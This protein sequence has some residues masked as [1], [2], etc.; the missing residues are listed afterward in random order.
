[1]SD[2]VWTIYKITNTVN[3]KLYIGITKRY[4]S[5]RWWYHKYNARD[6]GAN[7]AIARA[8][9]K[10]GMGNFS[11]EVICTAISLREAVAIERG[12]IAAYG[13]FRPLGY[14]LTV[15][16]EGVERPGRPPSPETIAKMRAA[17]LG[18]KN[19]PEHIANSAA[20]HRGLKHSAETKQRFSD[21]RKGIP[22][23]PRSEEHRRNI[24][25]AHRGKKTG[26]QT[27]ETI[28][29]RR[30][31]LTGKKRSLES[32]Q[33][34]SLAMMGKKHNMSEEV[35]EKWRADISATLKARFAKQREDKNQTAF[36]WDDEP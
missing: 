3:T 28:E 16:G 12:L 25:N 24:A 9:R 2:P 19:T 20:A 17:K 22:K 1:M 31:T 10:H 5:A 36:K 33:R 35:R 15:G 23:G 14:N 21:M 4:L 30:R 11:I 8:M 29:K 18:R 27:A 7:T 13:T 26:P 34:M 32:R 6:N